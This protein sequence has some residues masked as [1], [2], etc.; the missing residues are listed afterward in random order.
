MKT[1]PKRV[2]YGQVSR[3]KRGESL[4]LPYKSLIHLISFL[5][6]LVNQQGIVCNIYL[7]RVSFCRY[8]GG[9]PNSQ[10]QTFALGEEIQ[11][12]TSNFGSQSAVI[13][14]FYSA[15][16]GSIWS[17]YYPLTKDQ[18]RRGCCRIE[19]LKKLDE[20]FCNG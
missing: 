7:Q 20:N 2:I 14:F 6:K 10:G 13:T 11:V 15:P 4:V 18:W 8:L 19:H 16:D 17:S 9:H 12:S 5:G 3:T 1:F